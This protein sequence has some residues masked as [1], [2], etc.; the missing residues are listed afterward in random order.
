MSVL[1]SSA[2]ARDGYRDVRDPHLPDDQLLGRSRMFTF[3]LAACALVIEFSVAAVVPGRTVYWFTIFGWPGIS[4]TLCP[5]MILS[6]FWSKLPARSTICAMLAG[7][8][9]VPFLKCVA[10]ISGDWR[11]RWCKVRITSRVC[12]FRLRDDN[13]QHAGFQGND[14]MGGGKK[15]FAR[16]CT[17][18]APQN[19]NFSNG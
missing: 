18:P 8:L 10:T 5:A 9:S 1:A 4:A 11:E 15:R 6:L 12:R 3:S 7:F 19:V 16:N 14:R 17:E 2:F 13:C